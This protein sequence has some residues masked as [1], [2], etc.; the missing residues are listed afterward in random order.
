MTDI[1]S[2]PPS[3]SAVGT[4]AADQPPAGARLVDAM[5]LMFFAYRDFVGDPDVI[6]E[7]QGFGR[8]HHRVVHFVGRNPGITVQNLLAILRITKQSLARV[9]RQLVEDG[10]IEQRTGP[11]DRRERHLHL[12]EKGQALWTQLQTP[13]RARLERAF[14]QA[15]PQ[16][17]AAWRQ[18]MK[19]MLDRASRDELH[20]GA[21]HPTAHSQQGAIQGGAVQGSAVQGGTDGGRR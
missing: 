21:D 16:A 20:R 1:K 9:L 4:A 11:Q 5:E 17:E 8:A 14:A 2:S 10:Q 15:G 3:A 12:T 7:D 6:L 13:Q 18:V 19:A